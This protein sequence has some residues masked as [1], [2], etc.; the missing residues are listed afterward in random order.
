MDRFSFLGS[1]H[2]SFIDE[3]YEDY[4]VNPDAIEPS[5]R[6]FF[7]GFDFARENFE[8]D[9]AIAAHTLNLV[10][11]GVEKEF[12][13]IRLITAYRTRGHL[14]THTN[15]V[16]T[17][18]TYTPTLDIENFGLSQEDL[19]LPFNASSQVGLN[20]GET[21]RSIITHL[22]AIYCRSIG[23]E[24]IYIR[25]PERAQWIMNWVHQNDNYPKYD[26]PQKKRILH[27]LNEAVAFES[28][29]NTKFVGQKRFSIEGAEAL[30]PAVDFAISRA[31]ELGVEEFVFG[32]AHRG[33]LN[34]LTNIM[35]KPQRDI[36]SEFE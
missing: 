12:K 5:W 8:G 26:V 13:V 32:M 1:A 17:R 29:L 27:K 24:F 10:P 4:L 34:M 2:A 15:P 35:G 6:A 3:L 25:D 36:F 28:F 31:A 22:E 33:R 30:I 18:R 21:L 19:D 14:F 16:R 11:E 7:Q 20:E 9:E 23:V